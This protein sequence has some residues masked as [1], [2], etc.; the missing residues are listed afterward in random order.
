MKKVLSLLA[1]FSFLVL[2]LCFSIPI[3]ANNTNVGVTYQGHVQNIG[4]QPA[5]SD[6][7]L[8]GTTGRSLRLEAFRVSLVNA[9]EGGSI[10]YEV[11][12]QNVGWMNPVLDGQTAGT[13]GR[14][15]RMEAIKISLVNMT[16]YSVQY[17]AHV[18]NIGWQGWVSDG[19]IAGTT[20]LSLR[21]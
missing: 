6:G 1:A 7:A 9:P 14:A 21:A 15:L 13:E 2:G 11:H 19:A 16:G 20:G 8:A 10:R 4:W 17:R 3:S 12:V 18:Q 5:V